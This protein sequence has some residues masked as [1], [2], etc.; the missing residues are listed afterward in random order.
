MKTFILGFAAAVGLAGHAMAEGMTLGQFEFDNRCAICHGLNGK[1]DGEFAQALTVKPTD[2]TM[3]QKDN[4]GV[5]PVQRIYGT[6][7]GSET[8]AAHGTRDMPIWG[9]AFTREAENDLGYYALPPDEAAEYAKG[10]ILALIEY[11]STLQAK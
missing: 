10:R 8:V 5:F 3:L 9:R 11:L 2:L 4:G 7:D 6:I 1:G